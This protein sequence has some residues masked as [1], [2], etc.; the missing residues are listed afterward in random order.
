M[1]PLSAK[2]ILERIILHDGNCSGEEIKCKTCPLDK[3]DMC[4]TEGINPWDM[5]ASA[6]RRLQLAQKMLYELIFAEELESALA[7]DT[8]SINP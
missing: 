4:V 1:Q 2:Q 7:A 5:E 8:D 3:D 6:P